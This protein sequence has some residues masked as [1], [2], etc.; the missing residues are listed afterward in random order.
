MQRIRIFSSAKRN[1]R[2]FF[3]EL[4]T[5]KKVP[6]ELAEAIAGGVGNF[7]DVDELACEVR[8]FVAQEQRAHAS[9]QTHVRTAGA[10][11]LIQRK[12]VQCVAVQREV[13]LRRDYLRHITRAATAQSGCDCNV[14]LAI[15]RE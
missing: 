11:H 12:Y 2:A 10:S 14:L 7:G 8:C 5:L 9:L 3:T 13:N 6:N 4:Q 1:A 15:D